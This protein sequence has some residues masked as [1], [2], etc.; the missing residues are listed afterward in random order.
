MELLRESNEF[1]LD[2]P[3]FESSEYLSYKSQSVE[4]G[5]CCFHLGACCFG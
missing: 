5:V 3:D 2:E 4:L 1:L